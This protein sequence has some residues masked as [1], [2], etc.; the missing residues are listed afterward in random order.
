MLPSVTLTGSQTQDV[1]EVMPFY[2]SRIRLHAPE[3]TSDVAI[4]YHSVRYLPLLVRDDAAS[5]M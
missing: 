2:R 1:P 4:D 5:I 3:G